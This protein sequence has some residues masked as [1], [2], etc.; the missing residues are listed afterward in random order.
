MTEKERVFVGGVGSGI[1]IS[2]LIIGMTE[3][4]KYVIWARPIVE[5]IVPIN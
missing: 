3:L 4:I 2:L 5:A 1:I